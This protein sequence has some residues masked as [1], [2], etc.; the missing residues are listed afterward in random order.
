MVVFIGHSKKDK[1]TAREIGIFLVAEDIGVWFD[2]SEIAAGDSIPGKIGQGLAGCTHF[3]ILWSNNAASSNWV[4]RELNSTIPQ[5]IET[6]K[7]RLIPVRLDN[8]AL[9]SLIAD[10][11]YLRYRSG[12]EGDRRNLIREVAGRGPSGNLIQSVVKKYHEVIRSQE[13]AETFGLIACPACGSGRIERWTDCIVD[14]DRHGMF[15]ASEIPAVRCLECNWQADYDATDP[16]HPGILT[17]RE[18]N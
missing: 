17:T 14:V 11:R 9:P 18:S 13:L 6:G 7:P 12:S 3:L 2:E 16:R 4:Q 10:I 15:C 5:A 1:D 8:T